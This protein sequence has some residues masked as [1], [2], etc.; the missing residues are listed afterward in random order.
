MK[1][2]LLILS[3]ILL[4]SCTSSLVYSPSNGITNKK[5]EKDEFQAQ[6]GYELLSETRPDELSKEYPEAARGLSLGLSYGIKDNIALKLR[7]WNDLLDEYQ[8]IRHGY[9]FGF[10]ID[11]SNEKQGWV[12]YPRIGMAFD[13][14]SV[15]GGGVGFN[16]MYKY[17]YNNLLGG[18]VGGGV[19]IGWRDIIKEENPQYGFGIMGNIGFNYKF[20]KSLT[21]NLELTPLYQINQYDETTNFIVSPHIGFSFDF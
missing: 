20:Y 10:L 3:A 12:F 9:S 16:T 13:E 4:S 6:G 15:E 1:Y 21:L 11:N 2:L 8:T 14:N 5:I 18:Y 19:L 7:G 17:N